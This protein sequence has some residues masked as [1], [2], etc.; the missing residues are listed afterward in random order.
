MSNETTFPSPIHIVQRDHLPPLRFRGQIIGSA[1]D[2]GINSTRWNVWTLYRTDAGR[3][4]LHIRHRTQ[5]QGERTT[6]AA[7]HA[8]TREELI[9]VIQSHYWSTDET[10]GRVPEELSALL[11]EHLPDTYV[12]DL[13]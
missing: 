10:D 8:D 9:H 6:D 3:W 11:Q 13:A 4:V 7:L 2:R 5:W 1:D 12:V